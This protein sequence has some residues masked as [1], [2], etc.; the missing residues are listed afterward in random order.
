MTETG[1]KKA[2]LVILRHG[3]TDYNKQHLNTGLRDIPLNKTGEA[4]ADAL[5]A[6]LKKPRFDKVYSSPLSRAFNTVA[7]ALKTSGTQSHLQ[8]ADGSWQIEKRAEI[9]ELDAGDFTGRSNVDD[10]EVAKPYVYDIPPPNGKS[11]KDV[12]ELVRGFY[13]A[14]VRPRLERGEN[15][16]ISGHYFIVIA[17]EIILGIREIPKGDVKIKIPNAAPLV[18]GFEDGALKN[19][20]YVENPAA[21]QNI[22]P[23][24]QNKKR[25]GPK[26]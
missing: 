23:P 21:N 9:I 3:Q 20:R 24:A 7:R 17:F 15:V 8:N 19:H 5:G 12:V 16:L 4:Q 6:L 13:E 18:C 10:P 11:M 14:D 26:P 22:P 2:A 25:Q 1:P